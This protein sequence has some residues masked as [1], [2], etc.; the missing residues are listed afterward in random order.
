MTFWNRDTQIQGLIPCPIGHALR[1]GSTEGSSRRGA[2][3]FVSATTDDA[4]YWLRLTDPRG[5]HHPLTR[6]WYASLLDDVP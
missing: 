1:P 4:P 5:R 3:D 6:A 2:L